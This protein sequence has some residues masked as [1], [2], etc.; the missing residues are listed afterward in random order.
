MSYIARMQQSNQTFL[1][2]KRYNPTMPE[3]RTCKQFMQISSDV[4]NDWP[5]EIPRTMQ[6][7][8][9][10]RRALA[11]DANNGFLLMLLF[12]SHSRESDCRHAT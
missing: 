10:L 1:S 11:A 4:T 5:L 3:L 2:M 7:M 12:S 9:A 6:T 8:W